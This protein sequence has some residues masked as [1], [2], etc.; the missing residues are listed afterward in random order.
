MIRVYTVLSFIR[1]AKI[2]IEEF[3]LEEFHLEDFHLMLNTC[4]TYVLF[5]LPQSSCEQLFGAVSFDDIVA[6]VDIVIL[7]F[8]FHLACFT[9]YWYIWTYTNIV[10]ISNVGSK[11]TDTIKFLPILS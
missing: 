10:Q 8:Q 7:F 11:L 3:H 9:S 5:A 2:K 4:L 1:K 6:S